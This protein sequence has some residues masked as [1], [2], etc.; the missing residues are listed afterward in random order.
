MKVLHITRILTGAALFCT[1]LVAQPLYQINRFFRF[2]RVEPRHHFIKKHK[3]RPGRE[4][5]REF[6]PLSIEQR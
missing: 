1:S 6:K 3:P 5:P 2:R 4:R